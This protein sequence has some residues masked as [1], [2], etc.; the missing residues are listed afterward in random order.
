LTRFALDAFSKDDCPQDEQVK[1]DE[2]IETAADLQLPCESLLFNF[3][4]V[5]IDTAEGSERARFKWSLAFGLD[6][7]VVMT[8]NHGRRAIDTVNMFIQKDQRAFALATILSL[9]EEEF[10]RLDSVPGARELLFALP[11]NRW[12]IVSSSPRDIVEARLDLAGLPRPLVLVCGEDVASGK[13]APDCYLLAA[14]KIACG[15]GDAIVLEDS[16]V[17]IR[18]ARGARVGHVVGIGS[19]AL[20][21]DADVVTQD[22]HGLRWWQGRLGIPGS[23]LLKCEPSGSK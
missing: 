18:A 13:A 12:A 15:V 3:A 17:G 5:L 14:S 7:E 9:E 11:S 23:S 21:S 2:K 6:P 8:D 20:D 1:M 22:L 16:P 19:R 4:G 10:T